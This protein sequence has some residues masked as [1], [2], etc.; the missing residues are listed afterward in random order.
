MELAD[1]AMVFMLNGISQ[2]CKQPIAFFF[3]QG[4]MKATDIQRNLKEIIGA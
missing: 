1:H 2:K 3:T 4:A